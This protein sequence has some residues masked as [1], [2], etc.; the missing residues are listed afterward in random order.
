[1]HISP[2][3]WV[4]L[5]SPLP[6]PHP[7]PLD[8]HGAPSWAPCVIQQLPTSYLLSTWQCWNSSCYYPDNSYYSYSVYKILGSLKKKK[9]GICFHEQEQFPFPP[10]KG[11][12]RISTHNSNETAHRDTDQAKKRKRQESYNIQGLNLDRCKTA[13]WFDTQ[14]NSWAEGSRPSS[15]KRFKFNCNWS[16]VK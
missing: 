8:H 16:W 5:P 6:L 11:N 4:S 14:R 13:L 2:P 7:T 12:V 1:M 3:S 15:E 10:S 9:K